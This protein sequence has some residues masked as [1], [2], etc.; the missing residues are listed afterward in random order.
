MVYLGYAKTFSDK[1]TAILGKKQDVPK[2]IVV[3][4]MAGRLLMCHGSGE[5]CI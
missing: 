4:D 5:E 1:K 2:Q 3:D